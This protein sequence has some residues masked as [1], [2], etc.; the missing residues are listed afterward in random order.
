MFNKKRKKKKTKTSLLIS[1]HREVP[2]SQD[3]L[4][5]QSQH[6]GNPL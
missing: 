2:V 3:L 5:I 4:R 1:P 6:K